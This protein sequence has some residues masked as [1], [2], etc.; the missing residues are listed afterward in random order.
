MAHI[1]VGS[2]A[3]LGAQV[4]GERVE[5]VVAHTNGASVRLKDIA[6]VVEGPEPKFG[7]TVVMGRWGVLMT[8]SSQYGANTVEVIESE[9]KRLDRAV[10][11]FLKFVRPQEL[12]PPG[13]ALIGALKAFD[14]QHGAASD[15]DG[16][17]DLQL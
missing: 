4:G 2:V 16:L 1:N 7:D 9:I 13:Q 3:P 12:A 11:G 14:G 10:L 15:N 6:R 17:A 5:V 8:M